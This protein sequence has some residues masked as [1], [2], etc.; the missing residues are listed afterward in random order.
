MREVWTAVNLWLTQAC[1]CVCVCVCEQSVS[2]PQW[3]FFNKNKRRFSGFVCQNK[4]QTFSDVKVLFYSSWGFWIVGFRSLTQSC[5]NSKWTVF[6][7]RFPGLGTTQSTLQHKSAFTY[8]HTHSHTQLH[9]NGEGASS[10]C[11]S[12]QMLPYNATWAQAV[13]KWDKAPSVS[14]CDTDWLGEP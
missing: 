3:C 8:L 7:Q 10:F 5:R 2:C 11:Y 6:M 4:S 9:T 1:G 12:G 13:S 14:P